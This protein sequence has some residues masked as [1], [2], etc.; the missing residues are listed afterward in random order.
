MSGLLPLAT[1]LTRWWVSVYSRGLPGDERAARRAEIDSDLW[2]HARF[3]AEVGQR[4]ADTGVEIVTR[5]LLG[6]PADLAW[7]RALLRS[8]SQ[9]RP[10]T[11]QARQITTG[12]L[13][14]ARRLVTAL[15]IIVTAMIGL[16]LL[17][18]GFDKL[19]AEGREAWMLR[20]GFWEA[21]AGAVL[22]LGLLATARWPRVG[23]T[24]I[25]VGA[26]VAVAT[27]VWLAVI[28]VPLAVVIIAAAVMRARTIE[29]GRLKG[30]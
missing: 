27:H 29:S 6:I 9:R 15:A 8:A 25:A 30:A 4:P 2:E 17:L 18:N 13:K 14:M 16:F 28:G 19:T 11:S 26:V 21:S 22:L 1:D 5:L 10:W 12:G 24:L 7:R 3:D 20:L 23:T